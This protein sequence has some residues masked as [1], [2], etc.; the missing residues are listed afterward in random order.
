[1]TSTLKAGQALFA[2]N[3][4]ESV[5]RL[6][7]Y[8][9]LVT[10]K[11]QEESVCF[12]TTPI[13]NET[14]L[15]ERRFVKQKNSFTFRG[16]NAEIIV[17]PEGVYLKNKACYVRMRWT[18]KQ[19]FVLSEDA[20]CLTSEDMSI[21]PTLNGISVTQVYHSEPLYF[22][23]ESQP[24][25]KGYARMNSK[26]FAYMK[27][28][29]V[30]FATVNCVYV[31][32]GNKTE[33]A[34]AELAMK[35]DSDLQYRLRMTSTIENATK[36]NWEINLYEPKLIQ[37]TTVESRRPNENNAYGNVA[38]LGHSADH[39]VQYLYSRFDF[40][41]I[42]VDSLKKMKRI[43]LH[44]PY[45]MA[46]DQ[47][48]RV[49]APF[50]RFC[51]FGSN[52]A[53]KVPTNGVSVTYWKES[54]RVVFDLTQYLLAGNGKFKENNGIVLCPSKSNGVSVMAT[55]DNYNMPQMIEIQYEKE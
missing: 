46:G 42:K 10:K 33:L 44:V 6:D 34:G 1:M 47:N 17:M 18:R 51:S 53:N 16:S 29:F 2:A 31:G 4:V 5:K 54:D 21:C 41:K 55:A 49:A 14:G 7:R 28:K 8:S 19:S 38:F 30:P 35:K 24:W 23:F 22:K 9:V 25:C 13:Y 50:R 37:D 27:E 26:C 11:D 43:L 3:E 48:I 45:Y 15:V 12:F 40:D 39:G 32:D 36:L 20:T 52:W